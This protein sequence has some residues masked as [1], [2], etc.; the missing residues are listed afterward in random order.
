M[1]KT[2]SILYH[3]A[4]NTGLFLLGCLFFL[5][6]FVPTKYQQIKLIFLI[7]GLLFLLLNGDLKI[8][9][10]VLFWILLMIV[11]DVLFQTLGFINGGHGSIRI[12]TVTVFWPLCYIIIISSLNTEYIFRKIIN[13]LVFAAWIIV[14]HTFILFFS[15]LFA[16]TTPLSIIDVGL[17]FALYNNY[18]EYSTFNIGSLIFITPFIL[19]LWITR[20]NNDFFSK[21]T[22]YLICILL[23]VLVVLSGRTIFQINLLFLVFINMFMIKK[24]IKNS[25]VIARMFFLFII[26]GIFGFVIINNFY[27]IDISVII[28]EIVTKFE[29]LKSSNNNTSGS[30]RAMQFKA[31]IDAWKE[32]PVFGW[33]E[34]VG[35]ATFIRSDE[36]DWAYELV[37]IARLFQTG[38]VGTA[39][40]FAFILWIIY[41]FIIIINRKTY[42]SRLSYCL[43]NGFICFMIANATNPYLGKFDFMWVIYFPLAVINYD[44]LKNADHNYE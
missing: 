31:M 7:I 32:R 10:D 37:Y 14:I 33:G 27:T 38:I 40:Y 21:Y 16:I 15:A 5:S 24:Y 43:L 1:L 36:Q 25:L 2:H 22:Y 18:I 17:G 44:L 35:L 12:S 23:L 6:L 8:H 26:I 19:T 42:L 9:R 30:I 34:G 39:L 13:V 29:D 41:R 11:S 4:K 3:T 28:S 20:L